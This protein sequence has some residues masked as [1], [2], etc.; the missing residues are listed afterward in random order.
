MLT[1][2]AAPVR[3]GALVGLVL[4][5]LLLAAL[6]GRLAVT[7]ARTA[8]PA[9]QPAALLLQRCR[10][11]LHLADRLGAAPLHAAGEHTARAL[12]LDMRLALDSPNPASSLA[13]TGR[14]RSLSPRTTA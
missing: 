7:A 8:Q 10:L 9:T 6:G 14:A 11:G 1:A 13:S 3:L 2:A 12:A 5:L 4:L